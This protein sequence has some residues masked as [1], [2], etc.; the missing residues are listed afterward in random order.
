MTGKQ[1][2]KPLS[3]KAIE[4]IKPTDKNK[5]DTGEDSG[6]RVVCGATDTKTFSYRYTSPANNTL[7]QLKI[8][9]I[10]QITRAMAWMWL[11]QLE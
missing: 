6:L 2:G 3:S 9:S 1:A 4:T 11:Q 5:V 8:G 10:T 7:S